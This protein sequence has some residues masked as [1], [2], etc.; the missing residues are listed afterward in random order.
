MKTPT[1]VL[2]GAL[3]LV[4]VACGGAAATAPAPP[5]DPGPTPTPV[6]VPTQP[7]RDPIGD[8]GGVGTQPGNGGGGI[9]NP[10]PDPGV[11]QPGEPVLVQPVAGARMIRD[12]NASE[13]RA[14]VSGRRVA[15]QVAWWGGVEPC[16]VLAGVDV[17]RD[18]TT[19]RL[20]VKAGSGPNAGDV[21]CIEIAVLKATVVDLGEL[22]PGTYTIT[23]K[24][25]APAIT[26]VVE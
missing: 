21:A 13:L 8:P 23:A 15:V 22:E 5:A 11:V 1:F 10:F 19:I 6:P 25:D 24:G 17:V 2:S 7:G 3:A 14:A 26:V 4:L 16:D 12:A 18:G 20:T 9:V